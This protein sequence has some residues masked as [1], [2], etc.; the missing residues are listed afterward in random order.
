MGFVFKLG[1]FVSIKRTS[2]TRPFL[3]S[4]LYSTSAQHLSFGLCLLSDTYLVV[5]QL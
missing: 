2:E 3:A 5:V 1:G 4:M